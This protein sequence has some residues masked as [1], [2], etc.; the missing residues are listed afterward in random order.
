MNLLYRILFIAITAFILFRTIFYGFYE[1]NT[2]NN[3]FG[4]FCVIFFSIIVIIFA[5]VMVFLRWWKGKR[6]F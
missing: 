1:I 4:G 3:K 5:D 6:G 2:Q